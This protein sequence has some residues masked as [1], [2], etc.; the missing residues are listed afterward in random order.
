MSMD[1]PHSFHGSPRTVPA[2]YALDLDARIQKGRS[3]RTDLMPNRGRYWLDG[4]QQNKTAVMA[5]P[6]DTQNHSSI[7]QENSHKASGKST[8]LESTGTPGANTL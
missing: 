1:V 7:C 2:Y 3:D 5:L 6:L 4:L 8:A